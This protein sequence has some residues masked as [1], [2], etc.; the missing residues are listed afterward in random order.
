MPSKKKRGQ[1]AGARKPTNAQLLDAATES[2]GAAVARLL[3]A[4][5]D[6]NASVA[7]RYPS[8]EIGQTTALGAASHHG[9]VEAARLLLDAGADP[10]RTNSDGATPLMAAAASGHPEVL[11][12]LLERGA[13]VDA[14]HPGKAW[15]DAIS[16][17]TAFHNACCNNH[18]ECAEALARAGCDVRL[19]DSKGKTGLEVA[20][21]QGHDAVVTRLRAVAAEQLR[22]GAGAGAAGDGGGS[23]LLLEAALEGDGAAV[24]RLLAAGVDPNASVV[25]RKASG[26]LFQVTAL[27]AAAQNGRLEAARLLVDAGADPTRA[28]SDGLTPLMVAA[29]SGQ[30]LVLRLLVARG[31]AVDA[32]RPGTG[33]T[34]FHEACL[35]NRAECVEALA[36]AG[37]D[38]GITAKN[39]MT[40]REL[41]EGEGH[42]AVVAR[43]RVVVADQLRAAQAAGPAPAPESVA[44]AGDGG[45]ADQL[46]QAVLEGDGAAVS[47]LLAAGTDPNDPVAGRKVRVT[48]LCAAAGNGWLE[49]AR[50]LLDGGADPSLATSQGFTPLMLAAGDGHPEV[51]RLLLQRGAV[52]D[53]VDP[54]RGCTAFHGACGNNQADCAEALARAGCDVRLKDKE[55]MTGRELAEGEGHTAVVA[56]LRA[57]VVDQLRAAQAAGAAAVPEP[58]AEAGDG[59]LADQLLMAA[60]E[61]DGAAVSRLLAAGASPNASVSARD[62]SG[63]VVQTTALCAA[64]D[65]GRL[66]AARLLL[67]AGADPSFGAGAGIITPLMAAAAHGNLEVLRL[68]LGRGVAVDAVHPGHGRTAFH[69]ACFSNQADCVDALA[70]AGCDV[71]IK[72]SKGRTGR[73]LAEAHGH[74][75]V[76][77]R[78]RAVVS[79]QLRAAPFVAAWAAQAAGPT[80]LPEPAAMVGDGGLADQMLMA[81]KDGDEAAV[82]R[83]LAEGVN[84]NASVSGRNPSGEVG[85]TTALCAAAVHGRLEAARLLL[86]AGADPGR[87]TSEGVTPLMNAA[88]EGH[89][90]V[91]RL[92]VARGAA[93]DAVRPGT[94]TTSFHQACFSNQADCAEALARAG[95][96]I[97]LEAKNGRTGRD[98][99]EQEGSKDAARRL[100]SLARQPFVGVVVEL[101]GLVSAA[102]HNGKRA[103]VRLGRLSLP[104]PCSVPFLHEH[105]VWRSSGMTMRMKWS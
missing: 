9:R 4:G 69:N 35:H 44:V 84:P 13:P 36:R 55:G 33:S 18:P 76:V 86:D 63:E 3:A 23:I 59:G 90:G 73:E 105:Y 91:L 78:L 99:A 31:A 40:G 93:V 22:A 5:A 85:Q 10:T 38:V 57:V 92:L 97:G 46:L 8:G 94:E 51:L 37:C 98:M 79:D 39:G 60:L 71:G 101:A 104:A 53:A 24:V 82:V 32:T 68:L 41:A 52:V 45:L 27:C 66:E 64:A 15:L 16:G 20:E 103:M 1:A 49:V 30:L 89:P 70:R 29:A 88:G 6:P 12:L 65:F 2:D 58:A 61:G 7:V 14:V 48:A 102:E 77:A 21:A 56:R 25:R 17:W 83:L 80:P 43:L 42:T 72:D 19:K 81:A 47:R 50:L 87:A 28:A 96:N 100:R 34:A 11:R 54:D 95:C 74:V 26:Q 75:A 62:A 67:D